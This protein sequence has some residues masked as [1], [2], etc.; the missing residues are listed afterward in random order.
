MVNFGFH[1]AA[2]KVEKWDKYYV[3]YDALRSLAKS[4]DTRADAF[5]SSWKLEFDKC[6]AFYECISRE[7]FTSLLSL[8]TS[9]VVASHLCE[10]LPGL[11]KSFNRGYASADVFSSLSSPQ[12]SFTRLNKRVSEML[13]GNLSEA[14]ET[15][16]AP[17]FSA[18]WGPNCSHSLG[19]P[20]GPS[21][22]VLE[23]A[24]YEVQT[25]TLQFFQQRRMYCMLNCEALRKL[26]AKCS[27]YIEPKLGDHMCCEI[28]MSAMASSLSYDY[29]AKLLGLAR[30]ISDF[31]R[32]V[33][34]SEEPAVDGI[35]PKGSAC[36][37]STSASSSSGSSSGA[38]IKDSGA[39]GA[40]RSVSYHRR[41]LS[42]EKEKGRHQR[43]KD[44]SGSG[45]RRTAT[46]L[47]QLESLID[48]LTQVPEEVKTRLVAHRG[49]H[50]KKDNLDRP[51]ENTIAA[52]EQAWTAGMAYCECDITLTLDNKLVLCH[53]SDL[54]RLAHARG[55]QGDGRESKAMKPVTQLTFDELY[56]FPLKNGTYAPLLVDVLQCARRAG[57]D[58]QLVI[59]IKPGADGSQVAATLCYLLCDNRELLRRVAV[60]MSFDLYIVHNFCRF[61]EATMEINNAALGR[62]AEEGSDGS[63]K[64]V[65]P[66]ILFLTKNP[67]DSGV[68]HEMSVDW[69]NQTSEEIKQQLEGYITRG[70]TSLDGLYVQYHP[71]MENVDSKASRLL[72]EMAE[73][74]TLGVWGAAKD[75]DNAKCASMLSTRGFTFINT[76]LPSSF[77][78][79]GLAHYET[80]NEITTCTDDD[81]P[82]SDEGEASYNSDF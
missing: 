55:Q 77:L 40:T 6:N 57:P 9:N 67:D 75:P 13:D 39:G 79:C 31:R 76:D 33:D 44:G 47:S 4:S 7:A 48:M 19:H 66:R 26:A 59:E 54:F 62:Q 27:K 52:Y 64:L 51:L 2:S 35:Q 10:E 17:L 46:G 73:T 11:C 72:K 43:R 61:F 8:R 80:N 5:F 21:L 30:L 41:K 63:Q 78:R 60:V 24:L 74:H 71:S 16:A 28:S 53:D 42:K 12:T 70:N 58:A 18:M 3:D 56:Q 45:S 81:H 37:E 20:D 82:S 15:D 49:F 14:S 69:K 68:E 25:T 29:S 34:E 36:I 38:N 65:R 23:K 1:L 50:S 32:D 22:D